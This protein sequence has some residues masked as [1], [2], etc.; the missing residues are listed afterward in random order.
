MHGNC[1]YSMKQK[2]FR[3]RI[4]V[5]YFIFFG[6]LLC[7]GWYDYSRISG[8][9]SGLIIIGVCIIFCVFAFYSGYYVLTDKE[10]RIYYMW[11]IA[12]KP[13]GRILISAITSVERTYSPAQSPAASAKRLRFRFKKGYKWRLFFSNSPFVI[14]IAPLISPVREQE[15][16]ETLKAL[17]PDIHI[18]VHDKKRWWRFLIWD[19]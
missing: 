4:G 1:V 13:Y 10:I 18:N 7:F 17:N 11:G 12:G 6:A 14:I 15:F 3:S 9:F 16:L 8:S 5:Y 2:V 19:F